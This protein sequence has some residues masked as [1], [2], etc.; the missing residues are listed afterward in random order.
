MAWCRRSGMD[1]LCRQGLSRFV[2]LRS[3]SNHIKTSVLQYPLLA[4]ISFLVIITRRTLYEQ[5]F[6]HPVSRINL[7]LW[8]FSFYYSVT[9]TNITLWYPP[10]NYPV[11]PINLELWY[12][13]LH[14]TV[15]GTSL[16][17]WWLTLYYSVNTFWR[18]HNGETK[19]V[20][21]FK[22]PYVIQSSGHT[23]SFS[24]FFFSYLYLLSSRFPFSFIFCFIYSF[25]FVSTYLSRR[26]ITMEG[27]KLSLY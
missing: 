20:C 16:T 26:F 8:C 3:S 22:S 21:A 23:S 14:Y 6:S 24:S 9:P 17:F 25:P 13:P 5:P 2:L 11:I 27:A 1:I 4:S 10:L 19:I 12:S 7:M 18:W 15:S